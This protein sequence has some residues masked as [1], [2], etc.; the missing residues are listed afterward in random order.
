MKWEIREAKPGDILR[1]PIG[2]QLMHY[3][4]FVSEDEVIQFGLPPRHGVSGGDV[5]VLASDIS[6]FAGGDYPEVAVL[7][8]R[9]RLRRYPRKKTVA[10]AR[11]RLGE[12]GYHLLYNNCEHFVYE[13]VF[14]RHES[15]GARQAL[16]L[17]GHVSLC[18]VYLMEFDDRFPPRVDFPPRQAEIDA[19]QNPRVQREKAAVFALADYAVRHVLGVGLATLHPHK[20]ENGKWEADLLS[21]SFS[22]TDGLAAVAVSLAPVGVDVQ[23]LPLQRPD[24]VRRVLTE[25]E[26]AANPTDAALG[27]LWCRKESIFKRTGSAAFDPRKTESGAADCRSRTLHMGTQ[28]Y[29]AAVCGEMAEGVRFFTVTPGHREPVVVP[30]PEEETGGKA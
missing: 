3:G 4:I 24:S 8:F 13:C 17:F 19:C 18:N 28:A 25:P 10:I 16:R 23:S 15:H 5:Q 2:G 27:E 14:G 29:A 12:G 9:E 11:A 7:S 26:A 30:L 20:T 21:L 6:T 22:H 1:V